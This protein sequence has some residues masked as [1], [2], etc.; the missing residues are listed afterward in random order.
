M[1]KAKAL[2]IKFDTPVM[3]A[4]GLTTLVF[5][6]LGLLW[7]SRKAIADT[8]VSA[9][10]TGTGVVHDVIGITRDV[11]ED[12]KTL[13]SRSWA[14]QQVDDLKDW[15]GLGE[16]SG[17]DL[18]EQGIYNKDGGYPSELPVFNEEGQIVLPPY[19]VTPYS[20]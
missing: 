13:G 17:P 18:Y 20:N 12:S 7:F 19:G 15:L 10:K 3:L 14:S 2:N 11:K 8:A 9:S 4:V 6:V 16:D 5:A 1:A